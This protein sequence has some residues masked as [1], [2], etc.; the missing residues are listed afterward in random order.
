M[1]VTWL[2]HS[3]FCIQ[4]E[5][6]KLLID[7]FL[8]DSPTRPDNI[9]CFIEGTDYILLTHG[10]PDH[11]GDALSIITKSN[12][13]AVS[14][15]E[16]C[17]WLVANGAKRDNCVDMN[18]GGSVQFRS[19]KVNMV[20]AVH[21][22][23]LLNAD[24]TF[25][26]GGYP[27]GFVI[28]VGDARIYHSGDTGVFSDMKLI[29]DIYAPSIGLLPIGGRFTMSPETAAYACN[30]LLNLKQIIPMHHGTFP[31]LTGDPYA[32]KELVTRGEVVVLKPGESVTY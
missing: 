4:S 1:K 11:V 19:L 9:A 30:N 26:Y 20:Q 18:I 31:L 12:T 14:S 5:D 8:S 6:V 25:S 15:F 10:H 3:S 24:G 21:S 2:G 17:N 29:Q 27:A 23:S 22:N 32:F 28:E 16:I 7:P 13:V